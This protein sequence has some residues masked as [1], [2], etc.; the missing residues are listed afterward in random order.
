MDA[1]KISSSIPTVDESKS[2]PSDAIHKTK[3]GQKKANQNSSNLVGDSNK[4]ETTS[5]KLD[6]DIG[7]LQLLDN[8]YRSD[9]DQELSSNNDTLKEAIT[10]GIRNNF[11]I[12]TNNSSTNQTNIK[13]PINNC[14]SSKSILTTAITVTTFEVKSSVAV[15]YNTSPRLVST[16]NCDISNPHLNKISNSKYLSKTQSLD[17][18]EEP[19]NSFND[20]DCVDGSYSVSDEQIAN[21]S[22]SAERKS[23][24]GAINKT[25]VPAI[26]AMMPKI[27]SLDNNHPRPIY[28]NLPYSPYNSPFGSPRTGRRRVPLRESRRVSIEKTGSFL[29]LN[30]YKL[31]DQIGQ[32]LFS[33][34]LHS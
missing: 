8:N 6:S 21:C 24:T 20:V 18:V 1:S 7:N 4:N 23:A 5:I 14:L 29:Q 3:N 9:Q 19:C 17:I 30:Q 26:K 34:Y 32:V 27:S 10:E 11:A 25:T 22:Q 28:A 2:L 33:F 16:K 12:I 15:A 13:N 31:L